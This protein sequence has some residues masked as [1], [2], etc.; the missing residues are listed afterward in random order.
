MAVETQE[1]GAASARSTRR[2]GGGGSDGHRS[3]VAPTWPQ[4]MVNPIREYG[5]GS[6]Q[7]LARLQG[8]EPTGRPEAELWM[9]AHPLASSQLLQPDGSQVSLAVA[10][11]TDPVAILGVQCADRFGARLPF[12]LKVLAVDRALSIQVHPTPA[13]AAAG[14]AREEAAGLPGSQRSYGDPYAKPEM[15]VAVTDFVALAGLRDNSHV[16]R[17]LG[18]L[19]IPALEPV[20]E[21][22]ESPAPQGAG[23]LGTAQAL[24]MLA[25]WPQADRAAL[26]AASAA[27]A[28]EVLAGRDTGLGPA[29]RADLEWVL[30]LA[31]Q[32]P[33]DPM[34]VA[35]LVLRRHRLTP[36]EAVFLPAGV[37]HAYL[38]GMGV[39]VMASSDNVVRAGLTSKRVD[40][41]A[42]TALLD[43]CAEVMPRVPRVPAG[44]AG[45]LWQP[46]VEEFALSRLVVDGR[47]AV[48]TDDPDGPQVLL[49]LAGNVEITADGHQVGLSGGQSA[50][51]G[52]SASP[53]VIAGTGEVYRATVGSRRT[54]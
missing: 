15:L 53:V 1:T 4:L 29:D 19:D 13:Q 26:A 2:T 8:R 24:A 35:P 38:S 20:L 23:R 21:A 22:L 11:E 48:L 28:G 30:V 44:A 34:V 14:Y 36:G 5:W 47:P 18:L 32:H 10:I 25:T 46:E 12:L 50:F 16:A 3:A 39:E 17:L 45:E 54:A 51:L 9:G 52:A 31:G 33:A 42:L 7:A 6:T 27:R 49:C 37:P 40:A 43:P 41:E